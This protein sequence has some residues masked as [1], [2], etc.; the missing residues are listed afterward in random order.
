MVGPTSGMVPDVMVALG[1]DLNNRGTTEAFRF[2]STKE[3][4]VRFYLTTLSE[5]D[6]TRWL[7]EDQPSSAGLGIETPRAAV[8]LQPDSSTVPPGDAALLSGDTA[9]LPGDAALPS[10]GDYAPGEVTVTIRGLV[11][12]WMPLPQAQVQA[13]DVQAG[14]DPRQWEWN[15]TS[16]TARSQTQTTGWDDQYTARS[17]PMVAEP[18]LRDLATVLPAYSTS[19]APPGTDVPAGYGPYL[20]LPSPA[21]PALAAEA[22]S[23]AGDLDNRLLVGFALQDFFLSGAF[24]YDE[25]APYAP[26]VEEGPYSVMESF[27]QERRGYCVH[28]ASTFAVMAR[29]LGVPTRLAVGYASSWE[30]GG[31]VPVLGRELHAW[32]EI[33]VENIGWIAFEPT[34]GGAG[35]RAEGIEPVE[36]EEPVVDTPAPELP[37][38]ALEI[39]PVGPQGPDD[40]DPTTPDGTDAEPEDAGR[41]WW[42]F[43]LAGLVV[44]ALPHLVRRIQRAR[45]TSAVLRGLHPGENAWMEFTA[46]ALDLGLLEDP[47]GSGPRA[48]T[49][50]ALIE[51]LEAREVLGRRGAAA[52]RRIATA[53]GAERYGGS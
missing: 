21:P 40:T 3:G 5:Y 48:R 32:P 43:V 51:H 33:Y 2:T 12:S 24:T 22:E 34:P 18:V 35:L 16:N 6:G 11:S 29:H 42:L 44:L 27:L 25:A 53:Y 17:E 19:I 31:S 50:E 20:D 28:Y 49:P 37:D 4:P 30:G 41:P 45:R 38:D 14:L 1:N 7:P 13:V 52:A 10:D 47:E 15:A 8:S 9:L 26:G 23:L 39:D 36:P 46:T